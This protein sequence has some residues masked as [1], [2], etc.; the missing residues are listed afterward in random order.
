[1]KKIFTLIMSSILITLLYSCGTTK[2]SMISGENV[3][4]AEGIVSVKEA[5]NDNTS[6][7]VTV[8]HL[9][10]AKKVYTGATNYVVWIKPEGASAFQNVG[11][12]QVDKNLDGTHTT[13]VPYKHFM[14]LITPEL[15]SM[16]QSPTGPTVFEQQVV[17]Y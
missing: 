10:P 4:A 5:D 7:T 13:T 8:K 1:M 9:A 6:M 15:S 2:Q 16:G 11:A 17:R 12:L 14:V 3:P